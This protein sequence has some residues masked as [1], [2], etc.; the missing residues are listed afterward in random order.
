LLAISVVGMMACESRADSS[1]TD[2]YAHL[3]AFDTAEVRVVSH[4]D[5]ARLTVELASTTEQQTMGLME[6]RALSPDAGMLFLYADMQPATSAFW[7]FRTRIPLDIAFIDSVGVIRSLKTMAPCTSLLAAGCPGYEAGAPYIA[8]LE[9]NAGYFARKR[10]RVGD[11]VLLS[12]TVSR[13]PASRP[14]S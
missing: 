13:R 5:T 1:S 10:I 2:S 9:V 3:V 7:M 4:G 14:R 12:D 11:R 8:A 6:R